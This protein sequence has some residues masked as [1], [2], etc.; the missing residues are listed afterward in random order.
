MSDLESRLERSRDAGKVLGLVND[1]LCGPEQQETI[2]KLIAKSVDRENRIPDDCFEDKKAELNYRAELYRLEENLIRQ[3]SAEESS[4][5][6]RVEM[7]KLKDHQQLDIILSLIHPFPLAEAC[8]EKLSANERMAL[9]RNRYCRWC[10]EVEH[11]G[12]CTCMRDD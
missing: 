5:K 10:G 2:R 6:I 9:F 3:A 11:S 4:V 7:K 1:G 12:T 8:L